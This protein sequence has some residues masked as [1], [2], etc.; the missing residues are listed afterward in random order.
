MSVIIF[1]RAT[2]VFGLSK[3]FWLSLAAMFLVGAADMVS[4]NIRVSLIQLATPDVMRGGVNVVNSIF[5][6]A[7]NEI[8][9]FRAG[10]GAALTGA[11]PAVL[12]G[13]FGSILVAAIFWRVFPQL[14]RVQRMD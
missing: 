11:V 4:L 12:I 13:G 9:E 8:G 5:T 3:T 2:L 6:G 1:G 7:S 10:A 14:A